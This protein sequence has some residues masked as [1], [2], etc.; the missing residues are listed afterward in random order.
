[1][2]LKMVHS[3]EDSARLVVKQRQIMIRG[4]NRLVRMAEKLLKGLHP[5]RLTG[6]SIDEKGCKIV[7][8][9]DMAWLL[10]ACTEHRVVGLLGFLGLFT[11]N[12][13]RHASSPLVLGLVGEKLELGR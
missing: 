11:E 5:V 8:G 12:Y 6:E 9:R 1:M 13:R 3:P 2:L 7:I 4:R 10:L